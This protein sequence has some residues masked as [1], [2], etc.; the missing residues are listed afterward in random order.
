MTT[1]MNETGKPFL[2]LRRYSSRWKGM[3]D[4]IGEKS[5]LTDRTRR[6]LVN[7]NF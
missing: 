6:K 7:L 5:G 4:S 1:C 2:F 3:G